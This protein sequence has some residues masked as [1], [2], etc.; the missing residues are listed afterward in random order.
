MWACRWQQHLP[1][2]GR[3]VAFDINARYI[4]ELRKG[5]DR[6]G[7][8]EPAAPEARIGLAN[9][10]YACDNSAHPR[11][12]QR[13]SFDNAKETRCGGAPSG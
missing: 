6:D 13:N 3:V 4:G 2:Q 7:E 9:L 8:V 5:Y 11:Q 1:A 10:A 12:R